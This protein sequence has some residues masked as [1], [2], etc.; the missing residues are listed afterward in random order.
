LDNRVITVK[1]GVLGVDFAV[2]EGA[3]RNS[4]QFFAKALKGPWREA[5]DRLVTLPS[6]RPQHFKIYYQWVLTG[7]LHSRPE[8]DSAAGME[9]MLLSSLAGLG[10][11]LMDT[12]FIDIVS[13]ALL[14]M[15]AESRSGRL[16]LLPLGSS[17][18]KMSPAGSSTRSVIA[19]LSAWYLSF[20][21]IEIM[22][23][24]FDKSELAEHPDFV[25]DL[26]HAM[27]AK[28]L[29]PRAGHSPL[30]GWETSYKYHSHGDKKP[31]YREKF[32]GYVYHLI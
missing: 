29:G 19:D 26:L 17:F 18:Y 31:C 9:L 12:S 11:Y 3:V 6:V 21:D 32:K 25:M 27:A 13:D 5:Q 7:R 23:A 2:Y 28:F 20:D 8:Q 10:H 15:A 1:V 4:S 22:K 14:Q 16:L 24:A 30:E